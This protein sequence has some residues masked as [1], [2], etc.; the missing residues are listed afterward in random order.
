MIASGKCPKCEKRITRVKID[1]ILG[2][3]GIGQPDWKIASYSCP[4]CN[5]VLSVQI[6]PL[7]IKA[8]ILKALGK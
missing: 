4:S 5:S 1:S 8:D 3:V 2:S 7:A 6:D